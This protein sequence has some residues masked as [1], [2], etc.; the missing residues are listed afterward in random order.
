MEGAPASCDPASA[1]SEGPRTRLPTVRAARRPGFSRRVAS[2]LP[3]FFETLHPP[4]PEDPRARLPTS[5]LS[6]PPLFHSAHRFALPGFEICYPPS[7]DALDWHANRHA[8][9]PGPT[10]SKRRF[11][12][13]HVPRDLAS[14]LPGRHRTHLP[15]DTARLPDPTSSKLRLRPPQLPRCVAFAVPGR[16]S[17][18]PPQRWANRPVASLLT[19]ATSESDPLHPG[20]GGASSTAMS[21]L[22]PATKPCP[23]LPRLLGLDRACSEWAR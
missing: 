15:I 8:H 3:N 13:A 2:G 1:L 21:L 6:H 11:R 10:S 17:A 16:R 23:F 12:L 5:T 9:L 14:A 20:A 19:R 22:G 7:A 4:F 18:A